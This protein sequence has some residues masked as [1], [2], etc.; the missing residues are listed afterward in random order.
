MLKVA[1]FLAGSSGVVSAMRFGRNVLLARLLGVEDYGI[2]STFALL[3]VLVEMLSDL[4]LTRFVVQDREGDSPG[5][6]AAIQGLDVI[7]GAILAVLVFAFAEPIAVFFGQPGLGWAYQVLALVPLLHA[8][9]HLDIMRQQRTMRFGLMVKADFAGTAASLAALWPLGLWL[10]DFRVM[11]GILLIENLARIGTAHFL[12]ERPYR[13]GWNGGIAARALR[14]GWPLLAGGLLTFAVMQGER[15]IVANQYTATDLGLFSAALTLAM[16]PTLVVQ[17]VI[18][19][20][21]LPL[22]AREQENDEAFRHKAEL[23]LEALLAG[24]LGLM[25]L[26]V[27]AGPAA[28][29]LAYGADFTEGAQLAAILGITFSL[30]MIRSAPTNISIARGHTVNLLIANAVRLVSFPVGYLVAIRGGSVETIALIGLAG[31]AASLVI[32]YLLVGLREGLGPLLVRRAPVYGIAFLMALLLA[33]IATG[34]VAGPLS[35]IAAAA[36]FLVVIASSTRLRRYLVTS[37]RRGPRR[38]R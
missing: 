8:A 31:E 38:P 20:M 19:N 29:R 12:A 4:G 16:A 15:L 13:V 28:L 10:G 14:F 27:L 7:R 11:L 23:A 24:G 33:G 35:A 6:V 22:L 34:F 30:R 2:A 17:R 21:F 36:L 1:F 32:A 3:M 37:L 18:N 25:L 5:F 9:I 26:Y